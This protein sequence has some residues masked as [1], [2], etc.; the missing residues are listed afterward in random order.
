MLS[1][2]VCLLNEVSSQYASFQIGIGLAEETSTLVSEGQGV[3]AS[4]DRRMTRCTACIE[5]G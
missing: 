1:T 2:I 3:A 5:E 4:K